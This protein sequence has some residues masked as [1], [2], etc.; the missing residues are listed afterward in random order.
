MKGMDLN[1]RGEKCR[2]REM[3][4]AGE[5]RGRRRRRKDGVD[6]LLHVPGS[7]SALLIVSLD[8]SP[9]SYLP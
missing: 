3:S 5:E 9:D 4:E 7:G 8:P 2:N 6:V 1:R